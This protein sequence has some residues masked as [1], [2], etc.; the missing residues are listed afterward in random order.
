DTIFTLSINQCKGE[1]QNVHN[2]QHCS[3]QCRC[4]DKHSIDIFTVLSYSVSPCPRAPYVKR[5]VCPPQEEEQKQEQ[6]KRLE[7]IIFQRVVST[8]HLT[9]QYV[10]RMYFTDYG[11]NCTNHYKQQNIEEEVLI[12]LRCNGR[13]F[14]CCSCC[15]RGRCCWCSCAPLF[16][17]C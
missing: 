8:I 12:H 17:C 5:V 15:R 14:I 1:N 6:H 9:C 16:G 3:S 10:Y 13:T 11:R 7:I 2:H 4:N